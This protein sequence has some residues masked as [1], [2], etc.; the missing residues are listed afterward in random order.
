M[1]SGYSFVASCSASWW[2]RPL[3][4]FLGLP[5]FP[6]GWRIRC[7]RPSPAG[8][9][10]RD[11]AVARHRL[12]ER[13]HRLFHH[14]VHRRSKHVRRAAS[15]QGSTAVGDRGLDGH[16]DV[17]AKRVARPGGSQPERHD[18]RHRCRRMRRS[19]PRLCPERYQPARHP[20]R[21]GGGVRRTGT[22]L[23]G[24]PS[25]RIGGERPTQ[26]TRQATSATFSSD[27]ETPTSLW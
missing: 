11:D 12:L 25:R 18:G 6:V 23:G 26:A 7:S 20:V 2:R 1:T 17:R 14:A 8:L 24:P 21:R 9:V 10:R 5:P 13:R 16:P 3:R 15:R 22:A 4:R 27:G 19:L